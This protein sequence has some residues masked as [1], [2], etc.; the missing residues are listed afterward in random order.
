MLQTHTKY[1][2]KLEEAKLIN[3]A[4]LN[5]DN[6]FVKAFVKENQEEIL[7][8]VST[9][10]PNFTIFISVDPKMLD[11]NETK[12]MNHLFNFIKLSLESYFADPIDFS[13]LLD[14]EKIELEDGQNI[15][16]YHYKITRENLFVSLQA[17][18]LLGE[19]PIWW[20]QV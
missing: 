19:Y 4:S 14:W 7:L 1:Q 18:N 10:D 6:L 17:S 5:P 15:F 11:N 16:T 20:A 12:K 9:Y 2:A 13:F 3:F 8:I